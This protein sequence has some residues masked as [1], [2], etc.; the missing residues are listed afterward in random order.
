MR[1][2]IVRPMMHD[3]FP[4]AVRVTAGLRPDNEKFLAE[5]REL[6]LM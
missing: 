5:F 4:N 3:G 2:L 1:G 6:I